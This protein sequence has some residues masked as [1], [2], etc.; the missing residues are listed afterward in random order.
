MGKITIA[1]WCDGLRNWS[2][3]LADPTLA[4]GM[5]EAIGPGDVFDDGAL[6]TD[7]G[8]RVPNGRCWLFVDKLPN[9]AYYGWRPAGYITVDRHGREMHLVQR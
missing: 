6:R 3:F 5:A 9:A 2:P 1:D 8:Q 4:Y 7:D